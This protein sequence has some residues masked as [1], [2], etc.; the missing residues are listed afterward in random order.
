MKCNETPF[1][2]HVDNNLH[3]YICLTINFPLHDKVSD[4]LLSS[5]QGFLHRKLDTC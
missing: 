5:V 4:F 2:N 3:K 1:T